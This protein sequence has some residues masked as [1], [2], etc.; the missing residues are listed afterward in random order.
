MGD[1][2]LTELAEQDL[3]DLW[4][5][6]AGSDLDKADRILGEI[7]ETLGGLA[8]KRLFGHPRK[9][10]TDLPV[11]FKLVIDRYVVVY[12]TDRSPMTVICIAG[13][14]QDLSAILGRR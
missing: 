10:L 13:A 6:L 9:D 11:Y 14:T 7:Q 3:N 1:F 12:R 8:A 5:Y 4:E 2:V